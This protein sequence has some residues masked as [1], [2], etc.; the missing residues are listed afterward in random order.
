MQKIDFIQNFNYPAN[1]IG[2]SRLFLDCYA[3]ELLFCNDA[4]VW[5]VW[6]DKYWQKDSKDGGLRNEKVKQFAEYCNSVVLSSPKINDDNREKLIKQ[7]AKLYTKNYR[8]TVLKDAESVYPV[9]SAMFDKDNNLFNCQNGTY[10]FNTGKFKKFCKED[11][12]TNI[13]K[14]EFKPKADCPRFRQYLD[15]V[16]EGKQ[17]KI[18]YLLKMAAYGFTGDVRHDCFFVLYGA[19]TRNGKSTFVNQ[20]FYML[21]S[22]ANSIKPATI[23]RKQL[24]S[25]GAAATPDLADVKN[26]RFVTVSEIES[27]MMLDI[28]LIKSLTGKSPV[29]AR[30]LYENDMLFYP[31]FK[32]YID[33]NFLPKM[34]DDTI[35]QSDRL[36]LIEFTRHFEQSER[37]IN[38]PEKLKEETS[39]IFNLIVEY[40]AKLKKEGFIVPEESKQVLTRYQLNSNNVLA[41]KTARLFE[42]SNSYLKNSELF[43]D[44][45]KWC[46]DEELPNQAK[47]NFK[48]EMLKL[49][50]FYTPKERRKDL[51]GITENTFWVK[52][53]DFIE[54]QKNTQM[55]LEVKDDKDMPF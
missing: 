8:D 19:K 50:A 30:F 20:I 48:E 42:S 9:N 17:S 47:K 40:Y 6:N 41:F 37:D 13:S 28:A 12:I 1:D 29:K 11:Y 33:T 5:Y 36:H 2:I 26:S 52:G 21:G 32:M 44:Y 16:L 43:E 7:Y 49:G 51:N 34:T 18:D 53:F 31:K 24:N 3:D 54:N 39:G 15:E 10:D 45:K 4:N 25:G 35:F 14:V 46:L 38:L 27:G 23:T 22:Y 55:F